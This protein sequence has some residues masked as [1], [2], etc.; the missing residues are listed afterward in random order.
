MPSP[1]AVPRLAVRVV[2]MLPDYC[3]HAAFCIDNPAP[4]E[5]LSSFAVVTVR[6]LSDFAGT[7]ASQS[8]TKGKL[9]FVPNVTRAMHHGLRLHQIGC[10]TNTSSLSD[11]ANWLAQKLRSRALTCD[12]GQ[13]IPCNPRGAMH[14]YMGVT[15]VSV[16]QLSSSCLASIAWTDGLSEP[17]YR[18]R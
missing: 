16:L 11:I 8:L 10:S 1:I 9:L 3:D 12:G 4:L 6:Q 17:K 14:E 18:T 2:R 15:L 7:G 5:S 13:R